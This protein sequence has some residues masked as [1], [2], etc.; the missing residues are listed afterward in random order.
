MKWKTMKNVGKSN[1]ETFFKSLISI[2]E[3][4]FYTSFVYSTW[5]ITKG[6][7]SVIIQFIHK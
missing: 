4:N 2:N 1:T 6:G 3:T 5:Y 7:V